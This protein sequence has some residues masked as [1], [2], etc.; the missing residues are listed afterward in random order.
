MK[1]RALRQGRLVQGFASIRSASPLRQLAAIVLLIMAAAGAQAEELIMVRSPRPFTEAI[2]QLQIAI[3]EHG[4]TVQRV[5]RVDVGLTQSGFKTDAYRLVFFGKHDELRALA[6]QHPE[7]LPYLPLKI[8]I[9]AEENTTLAFTNNPAL[10]GT[11]FKDATLAV[12]FR[13]WEKDV[14]SI[15]GHLAHEN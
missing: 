13:R 5:Q 12:H 8:V 9:F 10:L 4:Y 11:F 15:L 1:S 14:R 2:N 7:L 3:Q 6:D